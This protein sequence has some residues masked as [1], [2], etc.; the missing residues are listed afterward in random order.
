LKYDILTLFPQFITAYID[1][2]I[3]KRARQKG[4][5]EINVYNLRDFTDDKHKAADDY[6][7]GG[8]GGMLLK[9]EPLF[10]AIDFLKKKMIIL[11][12]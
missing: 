11:Q 1:D 4:L 3:I 2:S 7:Y 6:V 9:P 5:V 10:K 12:K 8:G